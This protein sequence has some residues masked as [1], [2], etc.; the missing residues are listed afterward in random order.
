[1]IEGQYYFIIA[2]L[3]VVI[4]MLYV[5]IL[6][7]GKEIVRLRQLQDSQLSRHPDDPNELSG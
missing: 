2:V 5:E 4:I 3:V 7:K 1:M 6:R